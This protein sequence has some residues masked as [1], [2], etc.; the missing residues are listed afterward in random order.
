MLDL[1][2]IN[3]DAF[4]NFADFKIHREFNYTTQILKNN[5]IICCHTDRLEMLF[6][7]LKLSNRKYILITDGS[8]HPINFDRFKNKPNCIKKWF[9]ENAIYDHPDLIPIPLGLYPEYSDVFINSNK[10]FCGNIE[11]LRN[12]P[13]D[14]NLLYCNWFNA[15]GGYPLKHRITVFEKLRK[16]NLNYVWDRPKSIAENS[17]ETEK[18]SFETYCDHASRHKFIVCPA[19]NGVETIRTMEAL[20]MGCFPIVLRNNVYK[21]WED[22]PIIQVN[23]YID[24]T[25]DLLHSYLN[26]EYNY[27]KL[28]MTYWKKRITDE[29]NKL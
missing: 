6:N 10:W 18:L 17:L 2:F 12:N 20:Y 24:V 19:G 15:S 28:Y 22:T 1:D 21:E 8:D 13:K 29:F 27:E 16:N 25:Y 14:I 7:E 9:A 3:E 4:F 11:T 23:D 26:K 5:A